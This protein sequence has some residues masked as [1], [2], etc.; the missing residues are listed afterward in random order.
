VP[1]HIG[2]GSDGRTW[3]P[4]FRDAQE[5]IIERILDRKTVEPIDG[6]SDEQI[7]ELLEKQNYIM[8]TSEDYAALRRDK[9]GQKPKYVFCQKTINYCDI[10]C[11]FSCS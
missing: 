3:K 6:W 11:F 8:S 5:V 4:P 7:L 1:E 2:N 9:P 10:F